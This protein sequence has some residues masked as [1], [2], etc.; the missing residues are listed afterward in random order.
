[1]P[2]N[3]LLEIKYDQKTYV[4]S[5]HLPSNIVAGGKGVLPKISGGQVKRRLL[6]YENRTY[7][8]QY[9]KS[10]KLTEYGRWPS[11]DASLTMPKKVY[12][13]YKSKM[14]A[15]A[16]NYDP[17]ISWQLKTGNSVILTE[18]A[19][20]SCLFLQKQAKTPPR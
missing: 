5:A 20:K 1:M 18:A 7:N 19:K 15:H 10:G 3:L 8:I 12:E 13:K 14:P 9:G 16:A 11:G 2:N 4:F 6:V 17:V